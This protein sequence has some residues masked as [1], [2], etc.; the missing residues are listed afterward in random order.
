MSE[1]K[2]MADLAE[3]ISAA[4]QRWSIERR[5]RFLSTCMAILSSTEYDDGTT[6][7]IHCGIPKGDSYDG[8]YCA[9][10]REWRDPATKMACGDCQHWH[11]GDIS[12]VF[13]Y[14]YP[15]CS[16]SITGPRTADEPCGARE[17]FTRV[18]GG[19]G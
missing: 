11:D 7:C 18:G 14:I 12:Q 10:C 5:Q 9:V 15:T 13:G 1:D 2:V 16:D 4:A 17:E 6:R 8:E 19:D 3:K